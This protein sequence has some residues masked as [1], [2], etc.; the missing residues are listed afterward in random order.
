M[1]VS[2]PEKTIEHWLSLYLNYR[3]ASKI[4]MWL[5]V[6]G[7]DIQVHPL[8]NR[9]S[10]QFWFEV[11]TTSWHSNESACLH[12]LKVNLKQLWAYS[13]KGGFDYYVFPVPFW[14]GDVSSVYERLTCADFMHRRSGARWFVNWM[15]VVSGDDLRAY[16]HRLGISTRQGVRTI[17][18]FPCDVFPEVP[19]LRIVSLKEFLT[20]M[21]NCGGGFYRYQV[22][23][24]EQGPFRD[25]MT[26]KDFRYI[27][28]N[29]NLSTVLKQPRLFST[30]A[31]ESFEQE[32]HGCAKLDGA[33][34]PL[35]IAIK[36]P[37]KG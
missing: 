6:I 14:P 33:V 2:I 12:K 25:G 34:T 10:K 15:F 21:D 37:P 35:V 3:Y 28:S 30:R 16:L 5:P 9:V 36:L 23:G 19:G 22:V 32:A 31:S 4:S 8:T 27:A 20:T 13:D 29:L 17:G 26:T 11:K 24:D 1:P 18:S 7:E